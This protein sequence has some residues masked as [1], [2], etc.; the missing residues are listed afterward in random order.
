MLRVIINLGILIHIVCM[1]TIL[2]SFNHSISKYIRP[3]ERGFSA[4]HES[5][6]DIVL[7]VHLSLKVSEQRSVLLLEA[8]ISVIL[9]LV[10]SASLHRVYRGIILF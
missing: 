8:D 2:T 3:I 10:L 6:V 5:L 9:S 1:V 7:Q 4:A